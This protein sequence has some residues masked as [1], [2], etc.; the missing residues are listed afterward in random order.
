M[1]VYQKNDEVLYF[2]TKVDCYVRASVFPLV[3]LG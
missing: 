1:A 3:R 2:M